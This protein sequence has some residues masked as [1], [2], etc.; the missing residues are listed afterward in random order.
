MKLLFR[1]WKREVTEHDHGVTPVT[2]EGN[3]Y[4]PG[5][6]D[7]P[8]AWYSALVAYGKVSDLALNGSFLVEFSFDQEELRHWLRQFATSKPEAA[9]RLLSEMQAEA[10]LALARQADERRPQEGT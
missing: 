9:V 4:T 3:K 6:P 1:G 8:L 10:I 2:R 7:D 5:E